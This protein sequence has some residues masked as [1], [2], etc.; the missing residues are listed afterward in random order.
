M[1]ALNTSAGIGARFTLIK[2]ILVV[3][4]LLHLA[5]GLV[6]LLA[7]E[8]FFENIGD[9]PPFNR[10]YTGDLG[11][12]ITA[13]GIG[14]LFAARAPQQQRVLIGVAAI[15]N[16]LHVINHLYDD[17]LAGEFLPNHFVTATVPLALVTVLLLV[18]WV[19]LRGL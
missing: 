18:V 13:I 12:F 4:G 16:G 10:H 17:F 15:G 6:Q 11:A 9:F 7:P 5:T 3:L 1:K 14:L 8:W 19:Y 2:V